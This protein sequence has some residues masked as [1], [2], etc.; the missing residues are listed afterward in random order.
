MSESAHI[1][2]SAIRDPLRTAREFGCDVDRLVHS[3]AIDTASPGFAAGTLPLHRFVALNQLAARDLAAPHFGRLAAQRFDLSSIGPVGRAA[4]A[5]PTLG[6]ALRLLESSFL[7]IQGETDLRLEVAEGVATLSYRIL[8]LDIWP[9]DQD[10]EL[11][12]S[13]MMRLVGSVAGP[14]WQPLSL[15]FE[16][17]AGGAERHAGGDPRCPVVYGAQTNSVSFQDGLLDRRLPSCDAMLFARLSDVLRRRIDLLEQEASVTD[18]A[19][20][21]IRRG[22]GTP[23]V[24]QTGIAQDL[25]MSRRSLR[26]HLAEEGTNFALLL[27]ECRDEMARRLLRETQLPLAEIADRLGYSETSGFERA[28][29]NRTGATPAQYRRGAQGATPNNSRRFDR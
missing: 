21:L 10:A 6:A 13:V 25:G 9:R 7:A 12:I 1:L 5:A 22:I 17:G 29:R 20:R 4:L 16:H 19:R 18:K 27:G 15:G 26:R 3:A 8:D 23:A 2:T 11:T 28:F 14:G 24:D